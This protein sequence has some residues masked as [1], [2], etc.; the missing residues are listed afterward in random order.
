MAKILPLKHVYMSSVVANIVSNYRRNPKFVVNGYVPLL[1]KSTLSCK[2]DI[3][4]T[5]QLNTG[6]VYPSLK[7]NWDVIRFCF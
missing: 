7:S 6:E 5:Y 2:L 1:F 3:W 4:W